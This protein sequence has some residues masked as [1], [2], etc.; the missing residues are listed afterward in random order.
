[1]DARTMFDEIPHRNVVSFT[2]MITGYM[3]NGN[4]HEALVLFK[5]LL[6]EDGESKAEGDFSLDSV[7]MV[8]VLSACSR[9]SVKVVTEGVH[10]FCLKSGFQEDLGVGNTL[11]DAYAKCGQV[12]LSRTVFNVMTE[13]DVISWNSMIAV[14]AQNGLSK[15]ALELFYELLR[16]SNMTFN[17]VTMSAVLLACAHLGTLQLGKGIHSQVDESAF[18]TARTLDYWLLDVSI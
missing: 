12:G 13:R 2:S 9:V 11:I 10:G 14:Y 18:I 8:S 17:A 16:G 3:Q 5:E 15:E 6:L 1:M 4:A 7:S